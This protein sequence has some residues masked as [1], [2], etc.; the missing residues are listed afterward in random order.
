MKNAPLRAYIAVTS[1]QLPATLLSS[2]HSWL[3]CCC[4]LIA[5]V[6]ISSSLL[7]STAAATISAAL[8]RSCHQFCCPSP[9]LF[10]IF[11]VLHHSSL[12][13][14][15][16]SPAAVTV[17]AALLRSCHFFSVAHALLL[18]TSLTVASIATMNPMLSIY[19]HFL[20]LPHVADQFN[21]LIRS[22]CL[23]RPCLLP[24]H[25]SHCIST[26]CQLPS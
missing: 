16:P 7:P 17:S 3:L 14:R 4:Y 21:L 13:H 9:Q 10:A 25:R 23:C 26:F 15:L 22:A 19:L 1:F 11:A 2:H 5:A 24:S 6:F 18:P 8:H 12:P 20:S